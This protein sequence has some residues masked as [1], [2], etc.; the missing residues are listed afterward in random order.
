MLPER[1][2]NDIDQIPSRD[3]QPPGGSADA[4]T[5]PI[6][7]F[8]AFVLQALVVLGKSFRRA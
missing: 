8:V 6:Y 3:T 2:Q 7:L 1:D 5:I 4:P